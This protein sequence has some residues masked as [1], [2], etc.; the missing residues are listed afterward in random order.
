MTIFTGGKFFVG[1]RV[2]GPVNTLPELF[3][4][5]VVAGTA[6]SRYVLRVSRGIWILRW[7]LIMCTMAIGTSRRHDKTAFDQSAAMHAVLVTTDNVI[8]LGVYPRCSLLTH[9]MTI[10]A[11][12]RNIERIGR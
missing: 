9:A 2:I 10:P 7:K 5:T 4:N 1:K 11:K 6:G 8:D 3:L 12:C